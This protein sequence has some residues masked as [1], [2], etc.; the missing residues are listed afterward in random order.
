MADHLYKFGPYVLNPQNRV[1]RRQNDVIALTA[2]EFDTLLAIVRRLGNPI[3]KSEL[4]QEIWPENPGAH[5]SNVTTQVRAIR[6]KVG[7]DQSGEHYIRNISNRGYFISGVSALD[8]EENGASEKPSHEQHPAPS[9][10]SPFKLKLKWLIAGITVAALAAAYFIWSV[11]EHRKVVRLAVAVLPFRAYPDDPASR[12]LADVVSEM[13]RTELGAAR[14]I[15]VVSG[16]EVARAAANLSLAP[17]V[18][19]SKAALDRIHDFLDNQY[20][21]IG[22]VTRINQPPEIRLDVKIEAVGTGEVLGSDSFTASESSLFDLVA[23]SGVLLRTRFGVRELSLS[24]AASVRGEFP[25]NMDAAKLFVS[26]LAALH[27]FEPLQ[28]REYLE[29]AAERDSHSAVIFAALAEA[30]SALGYEARAR[31]AGRKAFDLSGNLSRENQLSIEGR[32]REF[33]KEW[34]RCIEVY[35]ALWTYFPDDLDYGL[36]LARSQIA[37]GNGS[38]ANGTLSEMRKLAAPYRDDPRI[39]MVQ[40]EAAENRGDYQ[41]E[42]DAAESAVRKGLRRGNRWLVARAQL[43]LCWALDYLA[44]DGQRQQAQRLAEEAE[45]TLKN[46]GDKGG[47][48]LAVKNIADVVDDGGNH[49]AA[50]PIYQRAVAA[51]LEVGSKTGAAVSLN[52]M[53]YALK[54]QGDLAGAQVGFQ[55]SA[56]MC[57]ELGDKGREAQAL[58]G[59]AGILYRQGQLAEA[60]QIYEEALAR[61]RDS[62]QQDRAA[63]V[64]NNLAGVLKDEGRLPEAEKRFEEALGVATSKK[65]QTAIA[66]ALGNLG[67]LALLRGELTAAQQY[68]ERQLKIGDEIHEQKQ[69]G[70]ALYGLGFVLWERGDSEHANERLRQAFKVRQE[71]GERDL[72][73]ETRLGQADIATRNPTT[74]VLAEARQLADDFHKEERPDQQALADAFLIRAAVGLTPTNLQVSR[75]AAVELKKLRPHIQ[76]YSIQLAV[77]S[78]LG[79]FNAAIGNAKSANEDLRSVI[80]DAAAGS[81]TVYE[82]ESMLLLSQLETGPGDRVRLLEEVYRRASLKGLGRI[83]Q[84]AM[85]LIPAPPR[86]PARSAK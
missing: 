61:F 40:A 8:E 78:S 22:S 80:R 43:R 45:Q 3:D 50:V 48:A 21:V 86:G 10:T 77:R 16:E 34:P 54:D 39:D 27:A 60:Q 70:Y 71:A 56:A 32:Y 67:D 6:K 64:L 18:G 7:K 85:S 62:D 44:K 17:N 12:N 14:N 26:G 81:Y 66:R 69:R 75:D 13:V 42:I 68:F 20:F 23:R 59:L 65:N 28:A 41:E 38:E 84:E 9:S 47:Q 63:T 1:L 31:T 55:R 35:R 11:E 83:A 30:W 36:R 82:L 76:D 4:L 57:R 52:N 5:E 53:A 51:F 2:R 74:D 24:E 49:V 58:N 79:Q 72:L 15:R 33:A 29:T 37:A 46:L 19:P 73:L 25:A